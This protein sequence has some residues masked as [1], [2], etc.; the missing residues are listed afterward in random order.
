MK[1]NKKMN[2]EL[3]SRFPELKEKY[4]EEKKWQEGDNTGSHIIYGDVFTPFI[5]K[6][7]QE[8]DNKQLSRI[9][10]F[11][12]ELL[13]KNV[14]YFSNVICLSVLERIMDNQYNL[15]YFNNFAK[16]KTKMQIRQIEN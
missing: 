14:E 12:E 4:I 8:K 5:E 3:I 6:C 11:I 10:E 9:C 2:L 13:C 7:I 16:E 15:E 1:I